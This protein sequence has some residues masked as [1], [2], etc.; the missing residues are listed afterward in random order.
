MRSIASIIL[1][2]GCA[3]A[4]HNPPPIEAIGAA[5][6]ASAAQ[7]LADAD[8]A[9][10]RRG[11]PEQAAA[12]EDLYLQAA[13]ADPRNPG[14]FAGAIRAKAFRIGREKDGAERTRLAE[15]AVITGQ[16]CQENA[17]KAPACDYWLAAALGLQARERSATG[18]DALPRMVDLLRRA[19][20][21]DPAIDQAGPH[22]LLAIVLLRAPGWPMGPGDAQAALPEAQAAARA[23]PEFPPNQLALGEALKKNGRRAD[24]RTAYS[25]ALRLATEAAA[26]G[27]PDAKGW[28]DDA[29]A[30]LR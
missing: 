9:W 3:Q 20:R 10:A 15:S 27:D 26:R 23:A 25:Q 18:H 11:E 16:L 28:V 22:R 8:A 13:R 5:P 29:S 19:I 24:A 4:L 2:A 30:A 12:A 17:P 7:L 21:T 6:R 14:S 1:C